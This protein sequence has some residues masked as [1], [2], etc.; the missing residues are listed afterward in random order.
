MRPAISS[1]ALLALFAGIC[2]FAGLA[3]Q[4][5]PTGS[6][7]GTAGA[8]WW[9]RSFPPAT[10]ARAAPLP[11]VRFDP[12]RVAPE[13]GCGS[14]DR[15]TLDASGVFLFGWACDP[16][17]KTPAPAVLVLDNG[18]PAAPGV[19]VFRERPDVAEAMKSRRLATSGWILWLPLARVPPGRHTF[20]AYAV[21]ADGKLGRLP[22]SH[23]VERIE[24]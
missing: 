21:L 3:G 9:Q 4:A 18:R 16:R 15:A 22:G 12:A 5:L 6:A 11:P 17:G 8:P 2:G 13:L 7:P 14:F 10:I 20:E 24:R 1:L 19:H 23:Q